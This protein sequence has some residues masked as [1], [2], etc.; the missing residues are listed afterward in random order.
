MIWT[1]PKRLYHSPDLVQRGSRLIMKLGDPHWDD[2][3]NFLIAATRKPHPA[4]GWPYH[5]VKLSPEEK[6]QRRE[7]LDQYGL[8]SQL[9]VLIPIS[10]FWLYRLG[11]WIYHRTTQ[12]DGY[13]AVTRAAESRTSSSGNFVRRWRSILWWLGDEVAPGWGA[14]EHWIFGAAWALWLLALCIHQ[15][16]T[17][18]LYSVVDF[19]QAFT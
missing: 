6:S 13:S 9:S 8:Y 1:T 18:K 19:T 10:F 4:M 2:Q 17:G 11:Q 12:R 14:R 16:G 5:I 3:F 7:L 15:T